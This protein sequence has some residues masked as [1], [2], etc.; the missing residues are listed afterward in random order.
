MFRK[1]SSSGSEPPERPILEATYDS[2]QTFAADVESALSYLKTRMDVKFD[3]ITALLEK[4]P[5]SP[6]QC[7][8]KPSRPS[9]LP[10]PQHLSSS[11]KPLLEKQQ[12][13]SLATARFL[14]QVPNGE[15]AERFDLGDK[16]M[17][18]AIVGMA[19]RFPQEATCPE[20]LWEMVLHKQSALS[21]I[22]SD[23]FN[24]DAFYHPDSDRNGMAST[25]KVQHGYETSWL[26]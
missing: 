14:P 11:Q 19:G 26:T 15:F 4:R 22:P 2:I 17:P 5:L 20:K 9:P 3:A 24:V 21:E 16:L 1:A 12:P 8:P 13:T 23:R 7:G 10:K 18:I 6:V 25:N